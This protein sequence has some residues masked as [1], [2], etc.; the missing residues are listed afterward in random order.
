MSST[1]Y[2]RKT[3]KNLESFGYLKQPL[4]G[5]FGRKF[6]GHDGSGGGDKLTLQ[7]CHL[8]WLRGVRDSG[9]GDEKERDLIH[10]II[11]L[12]ENDEWVDMW[13]EC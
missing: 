1:L 13:F 11:E 7:P 12:L 4:K 8:D 6:Y 3:P 5:A 9:V 10:K 2:F